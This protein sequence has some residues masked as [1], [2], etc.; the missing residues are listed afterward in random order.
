MTAEPLIAGNRTTILHDG[1]QT[2]AAMFDAIRGAHD[3]INPEFY[4]FEDVESGG[5]HLGTLLLAKRAQGVSINIL[6]I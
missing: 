6:S 1:S 2:F 4:T 3:T 5:E